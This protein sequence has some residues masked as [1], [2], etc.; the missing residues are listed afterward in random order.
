M[1]IKS[2]SSVFNKLNTTSW[3]WVFN[4]VHGWLIFHGRG[5]IYRECSLISCSASYGLTP[6][7]E[8]TSVRSSTCLVWLMLTYFIAPRATEL[9]LRDFFFPEHPNMVKKNQADLSFMFCWSCC[10]ASALRYSII[11]RSLPKLVHSLIHISP[12]EVAQPFYFHTYHS[13]F[14]NINEI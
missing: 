14:S 13:S 10:W 11:L 9:I 7:K 6:R 12:S 3:Q 5:Y 1:Q 2:R 4:W 8:Q